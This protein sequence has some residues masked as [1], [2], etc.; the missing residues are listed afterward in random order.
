MLLSHGDVA[1]TGLPPAGNGFEAFDA[2]LD[3]ATLWSL[4]ASPATWHHPSPRRSTRR[5]T[6]PMTVHTDN[7]R[8][9][10]RRPR[11]AGMTD[12][13]DRADLHRRRTGRHPELWEAGSMSAA[14]GR[15]LCLPAPDVYVGDDSC[16][17]RGGHKGTGTRYDWLANPDTGTVFAFDVLCGA[18]DGCGCDGHASCVPS[19][20]G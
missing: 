19:E 9:Y 3:G 15:R 6:G 2:L 16:R 11:A 4:R 5:L 12:I 20:H 18:C 10:P 1:S 7:R 14:G 13:G 8:Q 17:A